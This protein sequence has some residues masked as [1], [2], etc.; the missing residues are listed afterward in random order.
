MTDLWF[1]LLGWMFAMWVVLGGFDLGAG[2]VHLLLTRDEGER[3]A[4]VATVKPVWKGNDVFLIAA[5]GTMFRAFPALL[6]GVALGNAVR[7]VSLDGSGT[8][9]APLWTD[10]GVGGPQV[11]R[12]RLVDPG[13][14]PGLRLR[15][16]HAPASD[17]LFVRWSGPRSS[18]DR[19]ARA[20]LA[21]GRV[22]WLDL[23]SYE[24]QRVAAASD[25]GPL[26][27]TRIGFGLVARDP[28]IRSRRSR[29]SR[30]GSRCLR[31]PPSVPRC[32]RSRPAGRTRSRCRFPKAR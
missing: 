6:F 10:F 26:T 19:R 5:G 21:T 2:M 20:S 8:L 29:A 22:A 24:C 32:L 25:D 11:D 18:G 14:D 7:G 31:R 23:L 13:H 9:F 27:V 16:D 30:P 1:V 28:A 12:P 15:A 17:A 3:R 4:L